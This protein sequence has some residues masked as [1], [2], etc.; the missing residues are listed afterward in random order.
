MASSCVCSLCGVVDSWKHSLVECNMASGVWALSDEV[1]VEHMMSIGEPNAKNWLFSLIESL[2]HEQFT[3]LTI[4]LW[5]IWTARRKAIHEEIFQSPL[6][7]HGFI[8]SYL[9]DLKSI[10]KPPS[11]T[12]VHAVPVP[13]QA[14]WIPPPRAIPKINVDAAVSKNENRGAAAAFCR[15]NDGTYLGA[16]VVVFVGI[17]DPA[18]LEALACR[19]ALALAEDLALE[20]L[21]V[22]S[23]CKTVVSEIGE[24][25]LGSYASIIAEINSRTALFNECSFAHEGRASN[26]EAHSLVRHTILYG[27]G[28]HLWLG[29]PYSDIILVNIDIE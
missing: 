15:D 25:T 16:S 14:R 23:D 19:E 6:S 1:M 26:F 8:N 11:G 2:P 3:R 22:V 13:R 4:T 17:T 21:F 29:V 27:I 18:T 20:R 24:G 10:A 7:T 12:P 28:R 9:E 5:A